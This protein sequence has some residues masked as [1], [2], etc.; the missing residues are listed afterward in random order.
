MTRPHRASM[1]IGLGMGAM[2]VGGIGLAAC[3]GKDVEENQTMVTTT[4]MALRS[5]AFEDGGEIPSRYTCD[6]DDVSPPLEWSGA[7]RGTQAFALIAHDPDA[8]GYIHW[9]LADIPGEATSVGEG[10]GDTMGVAG[11]ND[12][13]RAG[14]GGPCPPSGEH[15]YV[16]NLYALSEPLRIAGTPPASAVLRAMQGKVLGE[17]QLMGV[18]TRNR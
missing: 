11:R 18:Y 12:F 8:G 4:Q 6:G 16:F 15:R 17:A 2:L 14:W 9:V 1:R 7:P 13:G 5:E 3:M 10:R